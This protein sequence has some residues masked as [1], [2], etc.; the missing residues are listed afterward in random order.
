MPRKKAPIDRMS[1]EVA[2]SKLALTQPLDEVMKSKL[3]AKAVKAVARKHIK[4]RERFD[5]KKMQAGDND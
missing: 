4:D 1:L 2:H 3:L 5:V